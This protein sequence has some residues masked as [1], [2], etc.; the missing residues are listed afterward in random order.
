MLTLPQPGSSHGAA[1]AFDSGSADGLVIFKPGEGIAG[2]GGEG[3]TDT[4]QYFHGF[5]AE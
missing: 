5:D 2:A 3:G 4:G 1:A